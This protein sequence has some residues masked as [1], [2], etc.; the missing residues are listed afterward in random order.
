MECSPSIDLDLIF[1]VRTYIVLVI[2]LRDLDNSKENP[3]ITQLLR[4]S[5][6]K[7]RSLLNVNNFSE[8]QTIDIWRSA[9][10]ILGIDPNKFPCTVETLLRQILIGQNLPSINPL[11]DLCNGMSLEF[12]IPIGAE[13][14]DHLSG[15][16]ILKLA[17]GKEPYITYQDGKEIIMFPK[18]GEPIWTDSKGVTR[19]WN[20]SQCDRTVVKTTT[21]NAC[22]VIDFL[23]PYSMREINECKN[24]IIKYFHEFFPYCAVGYEFLNSKNLGQA[25]NK[26]N[27]GEHYE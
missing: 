26:E 25:K 9:Y 23:P 17:T 15:D 27:R 20:S 16:L 7:V 4:S 19:R 24:Q 22:I 10:R 5:E 1:R 11:V 3:E 13:D 12:V 14:C 2:Y 18:Q 8:H 6:E 21:R